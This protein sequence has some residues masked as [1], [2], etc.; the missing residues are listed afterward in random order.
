MLKRGDEFFAL[1]PDCPNC[2]TPLIQGKPVVKDVYESIF[3]GV[4]CKA[5]IR[6]SLHGS[7]YNI[8]TGLL[9]DGVGLN[10]IWTFKV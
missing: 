9:E 3:L 2:K 6:C 7:A 8:R 10:S 4:L 1:Q 5:H